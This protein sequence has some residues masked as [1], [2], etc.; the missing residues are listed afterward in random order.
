MCRQPKR[1][2]RTRIVLSSIETGWPSACDSMVQ[3]KRSKRLADPLK[4]VRELPRSV[5]RSSTSDAYA[6]AKIFS[7]SK[8]S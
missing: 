5:N 1:I 6:V 4:N 3:L 8:N 2:C 7:E